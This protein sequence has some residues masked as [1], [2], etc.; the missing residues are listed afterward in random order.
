MHQPHEVAD[1]YTNYFGNRLPFTM[2]ILHR[3]TLTPSKLEILTAHLQ[4]FAS[5][6]ELSPAQVELLGAY[7]FDDP[8]GDV[9]IESHLVGVGTDVV[10]H[11]PL[12]YRGAPVPGAEQWLIA[13]MDHSVL[14]PRWVYDACCDPVYVQE[15][16]RAILTGGTQ[17]D[18]YV[19]TEDGPILRPSSAAVSGSGVASAPVP[20]IDSVG[21]TRTGD[22][23]V[24]A[25]GGREVVVHHVLHRERVPLDAAP[26]TLS[27]TWPGVDQP[28]VLSFLR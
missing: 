26:S 19:E 20:V 17:V 14:G 15:L 13:T 9:G 7:R 10:V 16:V 3:A 24:I 1:T 25:A 21:C 18:Q 22:D 5:V 23:S 27:G 8:A 28:V 4:T 2:A 12:T 6:R 11:V